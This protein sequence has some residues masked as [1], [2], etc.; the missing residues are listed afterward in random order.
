MPQTIERV[1]RIPRATE[2]PIRHLNE[3]GIGTSDLAA[4]WEITPDAVRKLR[5]FDFSPTWKLAKRMAETFGWSA[6]EVSEFYAER[7]RQ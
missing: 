7:S 5:R 4:K 6:G 3:A 2:N 1:K